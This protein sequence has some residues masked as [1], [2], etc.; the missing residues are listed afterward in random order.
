MKK[1]LLDL[2]VC[3]RCLPAEEPLRESAAEVSAT[4]I[5]AGTL[6]CD[7][8]GADYPI[9]EGIAYLDPHPD[10]AAREKNRY[11]TAPVVSSYLWSHFGDLMGDAEASGA[12]RAWAGLMTPHAGPCLDAGSAVGRFAFEMAQKC[13]FAVGIDNAV[14]FIRTARELMNGRGAT[15]ELAEEGQLR[16]PAELVFPADWRTDNCEFIVGDALALPFRAGLFGSVSSLNIVDKVPKPLRHL[17]EI[18]RVARAAAAQCLFSDPFSWSA[19][20]AAPADWLGGT[21]EG[22][23]AGRGQENVAALLEG[24]IDGFRPAWRVADQGRIDWRIRTHSNHY[25]SIRSC[26]IKAVR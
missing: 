25:E 5:A 3:P 23:F 22:L 16:R 4:D 7:R 26:C 24:R 17:Q 9:R 8:C 15:V 18:N 21:A 2:L 13:D 6:H 11:E 12:Y 1:I 20:V 10:A 14:A 19:E